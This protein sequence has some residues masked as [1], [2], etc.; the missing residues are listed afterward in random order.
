MTDPTTALDRLMYI[1][2]MQVRKV[3]W[4]LFELCPTPEAMATADLNAIGDIVAPLGLNKK[5]GAMLQRFSKDYVTKDVRPCPACAL[6]VPDKYARTPPPPSR[7]LSIARAL[8]SSYTLVP[9]TRCQ[10]PALTSA[11]SEG[12]VRMRVLYQSCLQSIALT[13]VDIH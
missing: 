6:L 3:I 10:S 7:L 9:S 5:R 4:A 2:C 8:T 11:R 1:C 12:A 13:E